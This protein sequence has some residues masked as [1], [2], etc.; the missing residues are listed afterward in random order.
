MSIAASSGAAADAVRLAAG[1]EVGALR[2]LELLGMLNRTPLA[3][4]HNLEDFLSG[5][6]SV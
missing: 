5:A 4:P 3:D 2:L 1:D 6:G